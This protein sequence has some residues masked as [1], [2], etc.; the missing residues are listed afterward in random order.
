MRETLELAYALLWQK[1]RVPALRTGG[2]F[3]AATGWG[4]VLVDNL[5]V[6]GNNVTVEAPGVTA[7]AVV[8]RAMKGYGML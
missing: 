7:A 5:K 8:K 4:D 6:I 2:V 3:L 1:E